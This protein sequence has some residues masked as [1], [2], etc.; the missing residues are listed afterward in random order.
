LST[1]IDSNSLPLQ[2]D[3]NFISPPYLKSALYQGARSITVYGCVLG[4]TIDVEIDGIIS[5]SITDNNLPHPDG[6]LIHLPAKLI[7]NQNIRIRQKRK[8]EAKSEWSSDFSK[9]M[10]VKKD[11][12]IVL[13]RPKVSAPL[14]EC[15]SRTFVSNLVQAEL[16]EYYQREI[17]K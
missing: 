4:A 1:I 13:P 12:P 17:R 7:V 14:Y 15:S 8:D 5:I 10:D 6:V 3:P 16:S 2:E 11:Y 9:V